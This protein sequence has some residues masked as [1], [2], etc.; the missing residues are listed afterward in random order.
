MTQHL[1]AYGHIPPAQ[2]IHAFLGN[3]YLHHLLGLGTPQIILREEE[4][5]YAVVPR[6]TQDDAL[7]RGGLYHQ[8]VGYLDHQA[9]SVAGLTGGV[10]ACPVLQLFHYFKGFVHG[11]V[12]GFTG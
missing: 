2:K 12:A 11:V 1:R 6:L 8:L 7:G 10:L 4:H 5:A 9:N 3:D